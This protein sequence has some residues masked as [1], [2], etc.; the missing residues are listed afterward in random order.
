MPAEIPMPEDKIAKRPL[1]F[2]WLV[3]CSGSMEGAKIATVN[4]AIREACQRDLPGAVANHPE[5]E[6][7]MRSLKFSTTAAWHVG[8]EA[9]RL[10]QFSWPE[11]SAEGSTATAQAIR[12]LAGE[13]TL[14]KMPRRGFP[15][16][17]ILLSDGFCTEDP[18]DY[19]AA[20]AHLNSLPWGAKAVRLAIG[21]GGDKSNYDEASLL[22]FVSKGLRGEGMGVLQ[23]SN[24]EQL[25]QYIK[26]ASVSASVASSM[27]KSRSGTED[28]ANVSLEPPPAATQATNST[29]VF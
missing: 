15:P 5:V 16:V 23:A 10:D 27:S 12:L 2:F 26:W 4:H 24:A 3:D 25:V 22:E 11:L 9:V 6:I 21:I 13:L 1:Q 8:P 28:Q 17:C 19:Q 29:D 18:K 7:W 20:I 14:E